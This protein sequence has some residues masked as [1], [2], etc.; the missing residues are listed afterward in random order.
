MAGDHKGAQ[1]W[2]KVRITL[3]L[4]IVARR[5]AHRLTCAPIQRARQ[6]AFGGRD[7]HR[8]LREPAQMADMVDM[9]MGENHQSDIARGHPRGGQ[10]R[11]GRVARPALQ[12]HA[13]GIKTILAPRR[14]RIIGVFDGK[15]AID[16]DILARIRPDQKPA[17]PNI[18]RPRMDPEQPIVEHMQRNGLAFHDALGFHLR[19]PF[20]EDVMKVEIHRLFEYLL[21]TTE[22]NPEIV[23][24]LSL[25]EPPRLGDFLADLDPDLPL[26]WNNRDFRGLPELR[27]R[28][29]EAAN[30]TGHCAPSDV[31]ITA[32]AAEAN[33]LAFMQLVGPGDRVVVERPGWPQAEVLAR[34]RGAEL[35]P[36][37]RDEDAGWDLPMDLLDASITPHTKLIFLT[38]PNNPTGR[39]L[40][41]ETLEAVAEMARR[42]G[43]WLLVDEVYAGLEWDGP[44]APSI[45]G[46]YERGITTGSVSKALGLQGLRTGWLIC[47]DPGLVRDAFI[48]RENSSEIMNIMGEVIAEIALRPDR[49]GPAL[50]RARQSGKANLIRLSDHAAQIGGLHWQPPQA[51]LIGLARLPGGIDSDSFAARLLDDPYRT[52]LLPGSS[53]HCPQHIRLGVGGPPGMLD[54]GMTRVARLLADWRG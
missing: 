12:D 29:L 54:E 2:P 8:G 10:L 50:D 7:Q 47:R 21:N 22:A 31:L 19:G 15:T 48:L 45:A 27:Q 42:A 3:K 51:G 46:L 32:G 25:T 39:I 30:L 20:P 18:A 40:P 35:V 26:D 44:R 4:H 36:V 33:Y 14:A 17:N 53:Y 43:A 37:W 24:G 49:L 52:F 41:R 16:K 6:R 9:G 38:N 11:L 23:L 28:V 34:A 1:T 5:P 13:K